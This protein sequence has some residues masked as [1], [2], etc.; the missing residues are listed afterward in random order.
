MENKVEDSLRKAVRY[1]WI[2]LVTGILLI[3]FSI[4]IVFTPVA[5]YATLSVLF[6]II[7]TVTG[8]SEVA[9]AVNYCQSVKGWGWMLIGGLIDLALGMYLV[10]NPAVT[11]AVLPILLGAVLLLRG[12]FSIGMS[13]SLRSHGAPNWGSILLLGVV[14]VVFAVLMNANPAFGMFNI[15]IWTGMAVFFAGLSRVLLALRLRGLKNH[16]D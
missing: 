4:W 15:V 9:S 8:L 16:I 6:S 7:L 10:M 12:V 3:A 5:S 1:W 14:L 11:M 13:L 2:P